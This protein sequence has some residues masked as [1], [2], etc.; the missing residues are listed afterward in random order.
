MQRDQQASLH[1]LMPR[2]KQGRAPARTTSNL[3][4]PAN[5][6]KTQ[7]NTTQPLL[8]A[9]TPKLIRN[10]LTATYA[11]IYSEPKPSPCRCCKVLHV[12]TSPPLSVCL[13]VSPPRWAA[14]VFLSLQAMP[15]AP[16]RLTRRIYCQVYRDTGLERPQ[17]KPQ[18]WLATACTHKLHL[19]R[20]GGAPI[21]V[22]KCSGGG[23]S[24]AMAK[25]SFGAE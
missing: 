22:I 1:V 18:T 4:R 5:E 15:V 23:R 11:H 6:S 7:H 12:C 2:A 25:R 21:A 17:A 13:H 16:R 19:P 10:L 8:R 20:S 3:P 9:T 14:E 24:D